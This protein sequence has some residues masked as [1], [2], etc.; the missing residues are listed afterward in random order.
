MWDDSNLYSRTLTYV[1]FSYF[2]ALVRSID[3][4]FT[5]W[6]GSICLHYDTYDY[7]ISDSIVN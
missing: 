3:T 7:S 5:V 4:K 6:V 2:E 1:A